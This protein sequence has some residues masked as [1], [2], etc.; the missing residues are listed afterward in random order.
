[1][2]CVKEGTHSPRYFHTTYPLKNKPSYVSF[3]FQMSCL[4]ISKCYEEILAG[5]SLR[6]L[7]LE[8]E[9]RSTHELSFLGTLQFWIVLQR[10]FAHLTSPSMRGKAGVEFITSNGQK[11]SSEIVPMVVLVTDWVEEGSL[12]MVTTFC[13]HDQ[14][15]MEPSEVLSTLLHCDSPKLSIVE[16]KIF[17]NAPYLPWQSFGFP[18]LD[19]TTLLVGA[20][21]TQFPFSCLHLCR[22][23]PFSST[24]VVLPC[25]KDDEELKVY[26]FLWEA[27]WDS[28][29]G[30]QGET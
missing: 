26:P 8:E 6:Q 14:A 29:E 1:M 13:H 3:S 19:V 12:G 10:W 17:A 5:P 22:L 28:S 25:K 20:L 23:L 21:T 18:Y 11:I 16:E 24:Q 30:D 7:F 27:L 2:N 15:K 9:W 4:M